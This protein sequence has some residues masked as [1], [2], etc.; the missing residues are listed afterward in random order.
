[1][2]FF[3]K[4][5]GALLL[6]NI[7]KRTFIITVLIMVISVAEIND[8]A[9]QNLSDEGLSANKQLSGSREEL[10]KSFQS[11]KKEGQSLPSS[12]V[13]NTKP[14]NPGNKEG[15]S[16]Q[17]RTGQMNKPEIIEEEP[18]SQIEKVYNSRLSENE[19]ISQFGYDFFKRE[20][21]DNF[22]PVGE[23]YKVGPGDS[24]SLY[25][26]GDPVD[27]LGLNGFYTITVD[28]DGKIFVP[29]LGVFYVWGLDILYIKE[30]IHSALAK[31]FKRFEIALTLGQLRQ[32]PVYVSGY[33]N[34]PGVVQSLGTYSVMDVIIQAGGIAK[35]GSLRSIEIIRK[36]EKGNKRIKVDL[37]SLF[38][39]GELVNIQ[40]KEGDSI[41]VNMIGK[42]AAVTGDVKRPA[43]Y[44]IADNESIKDAIDYAGGLSHSAYSAS[45]RHFRYE[46]DIVR[47]Y[48][49]SLAENS[50]IL[51]KLSDGD[52]ISIQSVN[53]IV[54][55]EIT[56]EGYIKYPGIFEWIEGVKLSDV[57][58]KAELLPDT[59]T[60]VADIKRKDSGEVVSFSPK[61]IQSGKGDIP[62]R[63]RDV[64]TFYPRW[65]NEPMHISGEVEES[66]LVP[67]YS[68][69]KLLEALKQ[70]KFKGE[71]ALLKAEIYSF[72]KSA[73]DKKSDRESADFFTQKL[74]SNNNRKDL[75]V[76]FDPDAAVM[77]NSNIDE[78]IEISDSLENR[79]TIYLLDLLVRGDELSDILLEPGDKIVIRNV[80]SNEKNKT[81]TLLG[82]VKKP[83]VYRYRSGMKLAEIIEEAGGYTDSA[84]PGGLIFTRKNAQKLQM[85]QINMAMISMEEYVTKSS[86][87]ISAAGGSEEEKGA[88][89]MVLK[90]QSAM[91]SIIKKKSQ[92]A[93]GR[94]ALEIPSSVKALKDGDDNITLVE[95][96]YIYI[97]AKPNYVLVLGNVYNQISMPHSEG[98]SVEDYLSDVGGPAKSSDLDSMYIIRAN[99]KIISRESYE[100]EYGFFL[101]FFRN[102]DNLELQEGDAVVVPFEIEIPIMWRPMLRDITQIIFQSISTLVLASSL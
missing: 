42:T 17:T 61:G 102:F 53:R 27:I 93:L 18:L 47:I 95:D 97:P 59:D 28:R 73:F 24:V 26:W 1:M 39:K 67:Y 65:L 85:N 19:K 49:G 64:I 80:E 40:V 22:L 57:L 3:T 8:A 48:E 86:A 89:A 66:K 98:K 94:L 21:S 46:N 96:D 70:I 82:E 29:N 38:I 87:G 72:N 6:Y 58:K 68:G 5:K 35:N 23:G 41:L 75:G 12:S 52:S 74:P 81:I 20:I 92:M 71:P 99:G 43:I 15:G 50:F 55:N 76:N 13:I 83:G 63:K 37:Y 33:V 2:K 88:I 79:K 36:D 69:I 77:I 30:I 45:A 25:F 60:G 54:Q 51:K 90:Q 7:L 34:K 44:E 100:R 31:K 9:S 11:M 62:L 101:S 16:D 91:L 78:K 56:V 10:I 32:F 14:V 84:Y 4:P